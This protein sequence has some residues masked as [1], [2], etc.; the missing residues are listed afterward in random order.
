MSFRALHSCVF[1]IWLP[2][3]STVEFRPDARTFIWLKQLQEKTATVLECSTGWM[4]GWMD[5]L[6][7]SRE[8][9]SIQ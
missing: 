9:H 3:S 7:I 2:A 6:L 1:T 4:D 5:A 8:I